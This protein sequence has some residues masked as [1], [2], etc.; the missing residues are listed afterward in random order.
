MTNQT[1]TQRQNIGLVK[2]ESICRPQINLLLNDKILTRSKLKAFTDDKVLVTKKITFVFH[3]I[4][5]N[6][7]KGEN[8][9]NQ[10]FLL[11]PQCFL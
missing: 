5:N 9:G 4:K 10:H 2:I 11:F 6:L 8:A 3:R 1:F 7:E